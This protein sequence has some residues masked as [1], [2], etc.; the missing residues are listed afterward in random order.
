MSSKFKVHVEECTGAV[1][2]GDHANLTIGAPV[3]GGKSGKFFFP[4]DGFFRFWVSLKEEK[5]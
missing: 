1:V 5:S 2:I 4:V 3:A